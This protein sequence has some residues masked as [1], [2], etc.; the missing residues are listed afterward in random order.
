MDD[1]TLAYR[2][3]TA[4]D[5][6]LYLERQMELQ[7]AASRELEERNNRLQ[8]KLSVAE[9]QTQEDGKHIEWLERE[10][11]QGERREQDLRLELRDLRIAVAKQQLPHSRT[12]SEPGKV[13]ARR[14]GRL[15][16]SCS[17][18]G[19]AC[20]VPQAPELAI[21][22]RQSSDDKGAASNASLQ[23]PSTPTASDADI[24]RDQGRRHVRSRER[25]ST[26]RPEASPSQWAGDPRASTQAF[27][28]GFEG[29]LLTAAFEKL[30]AIIE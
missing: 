6:I 27:G 29:E 20:D 11:A 26:L 17:G 8:Q 22:R 25:A 16:A 12:E 18:Q 13:Y 10:F 24:V 30:S 4:N 3:K 28:D 19:N 23:R 9:K 15:E 21:V 5:T 2:F 1:R 7:G 14:A